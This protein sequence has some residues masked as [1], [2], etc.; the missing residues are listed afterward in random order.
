[1]EIAKRHPK[2]RRYLDL[3]RSLTGSYKHCPAKSLISEGGY[4]MFP[5]PSESY[6]LLGA[7]IFVSL[8]TRLGLTCAFPRITVLNDPIINLCIGA[9][10]RMGFFPGRSWLEAR[11][12]P[13]LAHSATRSGGAPTIQIV[14]LLFRSHF[15]QIGSSQGCTIRLAI[16][17]K[18]STPPAM[19]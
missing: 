13:N 10:T 16:G 14:A 11:R 12:P 2:V 3:V 8:I 18:N 9:G 1:M 19:L 15:N 7:H 4:R 17:P 6:Y 5:S